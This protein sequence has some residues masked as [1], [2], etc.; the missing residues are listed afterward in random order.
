[1][2]TTT[3]FVVKMDLQPEVYRSKNSNVRMTLEH[4]IPWSD[5]S[6]RN[7]K[8][9]LAALITQSQVWPDEK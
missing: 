4:L 9:P 6:T 1:M 5:N 7:E 2:S 3:N 8:I